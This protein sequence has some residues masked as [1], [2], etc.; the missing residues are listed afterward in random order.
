MAKGGGRLG[1]VSG[2]Y[3]WNLLRVSLER[4]TARPY[5]RS[6]ANVCLRLGG[7]R[8]LGTLPRQRKKQRMR[9]LGPTRPN[10]RLRIEKQWLSKQRLCW[11]GN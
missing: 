1:A 9:S 8:R 2:I 3:F 4:A 5:R 6:C 10:C 7:I 11:R